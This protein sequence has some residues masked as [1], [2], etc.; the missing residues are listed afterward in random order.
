VAIFVFESYV[1]DSVSV[2]EVGFRGSE[3][4]GARSAATAANGDLSKS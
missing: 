1:G 2:T 3:G 4:A